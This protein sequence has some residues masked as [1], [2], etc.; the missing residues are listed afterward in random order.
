[1]KTIKTVIIVLAVMLSLSAKESMVVRLNNIIDPDEAETLWPY[2]ANRQMLFANNVGTLLLKQKVIIY[3]EHSEEIIQDIKILPRKR[4]S[5][6][7]GAIDWHNERYVCVFLNPAIGKKRIGL[8]NTR[9]NKHLVQQKHHS[10]GGSYD[11]RLLDKGQKVLLAG[12]YL[13]SYEKTLDLYDEDSIN[14][15]QYS[16]NKFNEFFESNTAYILWKY[17]EQLEIVDS[18]DA[19]GRRGVDLEEFLQLHRAQTLDLDEEENIYL[20]HTS[21][22]YLFRS[23]SSSFSLIN[24]FKGKNK[25]F[26]P[27]PHKLKKGQADDLTGKSGS[28]SV[29]YALY[30]IGDHIVSSF[31]QNPEG[32]EK[33]EAPYYYDIFLKTGKKQASGVLP[34]PLFGKDDEKNMY[35]FVYNESDSW[36]GDDE[37]YLVEIS[38]EE[39]MSGKVD[40]LFVMRRIQAEE[41]G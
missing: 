19:V 5:M 34:Y 35:L 29:P 24:E 9:D 18:A 1:M 16:I 15:S 22:N 33:P 6:I 7:P 21:E 20:I 17:N 3:E 4:Y 12:P 32:W 36:F 25:K 23:Y 28:Y 41:D 37:Y 27:I 11:V 8:F 2:T 30:S 13:S 38:L 31:Y 39:L 26:I 40:K 14:P 10:V